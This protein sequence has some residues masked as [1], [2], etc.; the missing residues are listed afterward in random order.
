MGVLT[1]GNLKAENPE[2]LNVAKALCMTL[3]AL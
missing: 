2:L 1:T 3:T